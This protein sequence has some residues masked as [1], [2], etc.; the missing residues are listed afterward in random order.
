MKKLF[1]TFLLLL[2]FQTSFSQKID[3]AKMQETYEAIKDAGILHPDYVMAQCMQETGN[4]N[5]KKCCLRYNNLFGF[6]SKKMTCKKFESEKECI[7]Y[8]KDWQKK[9]YKKWRDKYPKADYFH[10]LK[11]VN[12]ATGDKYTKE[13]KPK[14]AWVRKNLA[15]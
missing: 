10:F 14:L 5:C 8:Y 11:Y 15:L 1:S 7:K 6:Y 9:R 2:F 13:L 3:K 12:Y 4:L